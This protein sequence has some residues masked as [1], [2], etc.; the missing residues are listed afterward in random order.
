MRKLY[1]AACRRLFGASLS[2]LA[3]ERAQRGRPFWRDRIDG[4]RLF[5][6]SEHNHCQSSHQKER[7]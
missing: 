4:W 7:P 3:W 1:L 6:F 2:A 5:F